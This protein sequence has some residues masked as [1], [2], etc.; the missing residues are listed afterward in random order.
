MRAN[1]RLRTISRHL[2]VATKV[3]SSD[4]FVSKTRAHGAPIRIL[5]IDGGGVRGL[6]PALILQELE[7]LTKQPIH[8]MFDIICG[9]STGGLL[10]LGLGAARLPSVQ[11]RSMYEEDASTIFPPLT[12]VGKVVSLAKKVLS[13]PQFQHF[14]NL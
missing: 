2:N 12:S 11:I 1:E 8:T 9:T 6:I 3:S 10:A 14:F 7:C 13:I 5:C 4:L